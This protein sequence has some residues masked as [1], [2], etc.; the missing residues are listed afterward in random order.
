MNNASFCS[1]VTGMTGLEMMNKEKEGECCL[2]GFTLQLY[3]KYLYSTFA[4]IIPF[5]RVVCGRDT[6]VVVLVS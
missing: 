2:A 5:P 6:V 4:I 3:L 1:L